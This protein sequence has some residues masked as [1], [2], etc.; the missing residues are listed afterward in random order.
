MSASS[1]FVSFS[2]NNSTPLSKEINSIS[3]TNSGIHLTNVIYQ[4]YKSTL[5]V[6]PI[7]GLINRYSEFTEELST[8]EFSCHFKTGNESF[9]DRLLLL[10][11]TICH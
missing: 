11:N 2:F 10:T 5:Y 6:S 7:L 4:I 9:T 3:R 8:V 1:D